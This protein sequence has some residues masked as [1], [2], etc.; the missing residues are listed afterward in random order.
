MASVLAAVAGVLL[1]GGVAAQSN[2]A[3]TGSFE[4]RA[5][6]QAMGSVQHSGPYALRGRVEAG[7]RR[8]GSRA[9]GFA[10]KTVARASGAGSCP[11]D[12]GQVF[13][14]GFESG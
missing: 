5:S 1:V 11:V 12:P 13:A 6:L 7:P 9:G 10:L 4:L 3:R 2:D 14:D 8:H